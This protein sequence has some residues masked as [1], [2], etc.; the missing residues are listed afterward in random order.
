MVWPS[1]EDYRAMVQQP[2]MVFRDPKLQACTVGTYPNGRPKGSSGNF[3]LVYRMRNGNWSRAVRFFKQ[4][5]P[6]PD[7]AERSL[8]ID[9]C[10]NRSKVRGLVE[11][12]YDPEGVRWGKASYPLLTMQWVEGRTLG[13][14]LRETVL[15]GDAAAVGKMADAWV[16]LVSDLRACGIAHGDLQH[17]NVMVE[18]GLP[19]LVDYDCMFVPEMTTEAQR[20]PTEFG[21][22]GYQ[23]PGRPKQLLSADLDDF[24]AWVILI[25]L[26]AISE[27]LG[28]WRRYVEGR[29]TENL[30][31]T[32]SDLEQA[33]SAPIWADLTAPGRSREVREWSRRAP[34]VDRQALR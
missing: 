1:D 19:V 31:L 23:H 9:R 32:L 25:A 8:M 34:G 2:R 3:A 15:A 12:S 22:P 27:D 17:G 16:E 18:N 7:Q 24:S 10:I 21:M 6:R 33:D 26:R 30:L 20:T 5:G 11:F 4:P 14:W 28:L 29:D 13:L